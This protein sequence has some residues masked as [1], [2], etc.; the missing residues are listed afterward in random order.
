LTVSNLNSHLLSSLS[1]FVFVSAE[2][3]AAAAPADED[4][5]EDENEDEDE[6]EDDEE[7]IGMCIGTIAA[8]TAII[9]IPPLGFGFA[10]LFALSGLL[11]I[12]AD[13][14]LSS[15]WRGSPA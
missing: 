5:D 2:A 13:V 11:V 3:A 8:D 15:A 10:L 1:I 14:P 7:D 4:D 6:D 12:M 9:S